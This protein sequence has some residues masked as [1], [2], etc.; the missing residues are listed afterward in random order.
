MLAAQ[1]SFSNKIKFSCFFISDNKPLNL[2]VNGH[3][4]DLSTKYHGRSED[5][6]DDDRLSDDQNDGTYPALS[7]ANGSWE[8]V[9]MTSK[10]IL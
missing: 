8:F 1:K 3:A 7:T 4:K 9:N 2:Q 10:A 6:E 5:E